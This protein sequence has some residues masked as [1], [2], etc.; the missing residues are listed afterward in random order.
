MRELS[1]YSINKDGLLVCAPN[2]FGISTLIAGVAKFN[3][4]DKLIF[5]FKR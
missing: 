2:V 5:T 4:W 1:D 3:G